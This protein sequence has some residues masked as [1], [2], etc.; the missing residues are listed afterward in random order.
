VSP[1]ALELYDL[2]CIEYRPSIGCL[3]ELAGK[4]TMTRRAAGVKPIGRQS[5]D[6]EH[7]MLFMSISLN[8]LE[9]P[10]YNN[11]NVYVKVF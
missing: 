10:N 6:G 2:G 4:E 5:D 1:L 9:P 8:L 3:R 11:L 7:R